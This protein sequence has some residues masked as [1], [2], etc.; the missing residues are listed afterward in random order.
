M[1]IFSVIKPSSMV[2]VGIGSLGATGRYCKRVCVFW[3][4]IPAIHLGIAASGLR[5]AVDRRVSLGCS[6]GCGTE[7]LV[8]SNLF[9]EVSRT[10]GVIPFGD[11]YRPPWSMR[12][13]MCSEP[14]GDAIQLIGDPAFQLPV[15]GIHFCVRGQVIGYCVVKQPCHL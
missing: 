3:N 7:D 10:V 9:L 1:V 8:E 4:L 12:S 11:L 6:C 5:L 15:G 13:G 2:Y 14:S